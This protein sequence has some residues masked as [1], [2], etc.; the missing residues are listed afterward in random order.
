MGA[1]VWG[2]ASRLAFKSG[3]CPAL[4]SLRN[5]W[6]SALEWETGVAIMIPQRFQLID[7]FKFDKPTLSPR[8]HACASCEGATGGHGAN[9]FLVG[10]CLG[11]AADGQAVVRF[12]W[13]PDRRHG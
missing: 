8:N 5:I 7:I 11:N 10:A 6:E 12:R 2:I 1:G 9:V 13:N 4:L 3:H